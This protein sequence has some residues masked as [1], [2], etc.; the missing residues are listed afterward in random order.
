MLSELAVHVFRSPR[1]RLLIDPRGQ[2]RPLVEDR[3]L[4]VGQPFLERGDVLE[5][6]RSSERSRR[7]A[8]SRGS[9]VIR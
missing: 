2:L 6:A 7:I 5:G 3:L 8:A 4:R 1:R 9:S